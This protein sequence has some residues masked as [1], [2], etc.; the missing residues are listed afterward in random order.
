MQNL[1]LASKALYDA[2]VLRVLKENDA[3]K[4]ATARK[5]FYHSIDT[6]LRMLNA[7]VIRCDCPKCCDAD[8]M[9]IPLVRM[10]RA[11]RPSSECTLMAWF[12]QE[13]TRHQLPSPSYYFGIRA[14]SL[15]VELGHHNQKYTPPHT[16]WRDIVASLPFR[17]QVDKV[18]RGLLHESLGNTLI[19]NGVYSSVREDDDTFEQWFRVGEHSLLP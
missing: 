16:S 17:E 10:T 7:H 13:C 12:A 9:L 18:Y 3:L 15:W 4:K 5:L 2:E 14:F 8:G 19:Q 1:C 6:D 11:S